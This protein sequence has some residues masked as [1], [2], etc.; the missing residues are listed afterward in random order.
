[1]ENQKEHVYL[2]ALLHDIGK[3]YQ[4][5]DKKLADKGNELSEYSKRLADDICPI[6]DK[7]RFGYQHV[8][9]TNEFFEKFKNVLYSVP[10][11]KQNIWENEGSQFDSIANLACRHHKP[12]S[13]LQSMISLADWWSAGID[14]QN[15]QTLERES[16]EDGKT[17]STI[18]W[19]RDRYKKSPLYS[20][21]NT[22]RTDANPTSYGN[23]GFPLKPLS[24][25][26]QGADSTF[27][28]CIKT[29]ENGG[30]EAQYY[31]L[32]Q[33]FSE[34]FGKLP[35]DSY[36]AFVESLIYLLQKYTWC[37]PSNTNDMSDVSLFDHLKTTAAF[38]HCFFVHH[39]EYP[40][41]YDYD[42]TR[43]RLSVKEG[44]FPILL[45]GGD[46]SGIQKFIYNI[47]SQ[48]AAVSL[49]GRSFY[50]QL[51][52][53]SVIDRIVRNPRIDATRGQVVYSSG[54]KFY[55][56]LPNTEEVRMA[57]ADL[58]KEFSD[59]LW[60]KHQGQ[61]LLNLA[62]VPFSFSNG[63]FAFENQNNKDIGQLWKCLA[64][65]LA[66]K[67]NQ[68]FKHTLLE[69]YEELFSPQAVSANNRPCAVTGIEDHCVKLNERDND[70]DAVCVLRHVKDQCHLGETLKDADYVI[71]YQEDK[72]STYLSSRAKCEIEIVGTY[73]YLFDQKELIDDNA[74]FRKITS[75]DVS[76]VKRINN[77]DFLDARI[78]GQK[79]SY[80]FLFYGG[81]QQAQKRGNNKTFEELAGDTYLGVLRMDVD[82]LGAIFIHGLDENAKSFSA[83]STL[84][85][86]LDYFF[87]GLLNTIREEF[88]DDVNILYAGGDDVF[89]IGRWDK[90]ILFAEKIRQ[91]FRQFTGREDVSI[92]GGIVLVNAKFPIAKAAEMSG[93]A[94][95]KAKQFEPWRGTDVKYKKNA[96][97][98]FNESI[99]W[100]KEYDDVKFWASRFADLCA[101]QGMPRSI[102]HKIMRLYDMAKDKNPAYLWNAAYYLKR[103]EE[104]KKDD[105]Q[106]LCNDL[107]DSILLSP[108]KN[109]N[110][111]LIAIAARWAELE[112]RINN[113]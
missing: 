56:L 7:G 35:T 32:W 60:E 74:E 5:A 73:T 36:K 111:A 28:R 19:G 85:F 87:S 57:L 58:D 27:P 41:A 62:Y 1:M 71:T 21:F 78:K 105:I 40:E 76:L 79:T 69:R 55:M 39:Q 66:D 25:S 20:I 31:K 10:G 50:L 16:G 47:S 67:K 94:E 18:N 38:A 93:E 45:V 86:L 2:A 112:L 33:A 44:F 72:L 23:M 96:F 51:L 65:K 99:S 103:F 46:L 91:A 83:Y 98:L 68:K 75:A 42:N 109:R 37:I 92:S 24:L 100:E 70:D 80:G 102:L 54:G 110:I 88:K 108:Q 81:N 113:Q 13:L 48:K 101:Q 77:L 53:D 11:I 90:L 49:K 26:I 43:K 12:Q 97:T 6:N 22:I 8:I 82:G 34:D 52:I 15:P 107:K 84:S 106:K 30:N 14:R 59:S 4:R 17:D 9:W 29:E 95:D 89:A 104:G 63:K 61:L 64:D 3:F